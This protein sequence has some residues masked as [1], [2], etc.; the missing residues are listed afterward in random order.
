M[1]WL[2]FCIAR[3]RRLDDTV[4]YLFSSLLLFRFFM[5]VVLISGKLLLGIVYKEY[6]GAFLFLRLPQ[7]IVGS[8]I[9]F[10]SGF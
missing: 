8:T 6:S 10:F 2:F 7:R 1:C 3:Y 4:Y 9:R 5:P